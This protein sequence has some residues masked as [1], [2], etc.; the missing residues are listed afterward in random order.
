MGNIDCGRG[1]SRIGEH[2]IALF[3]KYK[4]IILYLVFGGISFLINIILFAILDK[5]FHVM[6]LISNIICWIVCVLFQFF[7]NRIWVF[8]GH[9]RRVKEFLRQMGKFFI[10]RL[11][12]LFIEELLLAIFITYLK[13]D[14]I[15]VKLIAQIVIIIMNFI[16]SKWWIFN[17]RNSGN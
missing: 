1:V 10:G 11:F 15:I 17:K 3:K 7:T 5:H 8:E 4:Q 2:V 14:S 12:T 9:V 13:F 16:I 6:E